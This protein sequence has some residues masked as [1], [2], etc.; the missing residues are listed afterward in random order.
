MKAWCKVR[1]KFSFDGPGSSTESLDSTPILDKKMQESRFII[2]GSYFVLGGLAYAIEA[3]DGNIL[4]VLCA[5]G[6]M[7]LASLVSIAWMHKMPGLQARI[8]AVN[9]VLDTLLTSWVV[10]WTGG[11]LSPCL[12]FY[13]TT[14]M[15]A[16]FRFGPRGSLLCT[17][18]AVACFCMVGALDPNLPNTLHGMAGT[19]LRIAFLF[20]AAGFGI[21][22]LHRKLERGQTTEAR[23]HPQRQSGRCRLAVFLR[24]PSLY[25]QRP[26]G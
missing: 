7:P 19:A 14:V 17:L 15:A 23:H 4:K 2:T 9:L 25:P 11:T 8:T 12:P 13:L 1:N 3:V 24:R 18:L 16:S 10:F 5:I 6:T 22:A 21:R 20:A 26:S